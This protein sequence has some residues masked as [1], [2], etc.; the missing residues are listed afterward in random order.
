[1]FG[2]ACGRKD[3]RRTAV[4][5]RAFD[6]GLTPATHSVEPSPSPGAKASKSLK[7]ITMGKSLERFT[8][9]RAADDYL[10]TIEDDNGDTI[11]L[12]ASSDQL[13]QIIEELDRA[14]EEEEDVGGI[15]DEASDDTD[16]ADDE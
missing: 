15:D 5:T 16:D 4:R 9:T 14:L 7:D 10:I 13:D 6:T 8:I 11:E 3:P 2:D 12:T 1:R